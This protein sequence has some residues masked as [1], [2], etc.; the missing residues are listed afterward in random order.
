M[1]KY[2]FCLFII[3]TLVQANS[4]NARVESSIYGIQTGFFGIWVHGEYG[5]TDSMTLRTEIGFDSGLWG[6]SYYEKTGFLL[7]PVITA[8]PRW[9]Y[10]LNKR[11]RKSKRIDGNTGNFIALKSSFHPDWFVI[12]N[13]DNL[14][15]LS[16]ISFVPTWGIRRAIGQHFTFETGI[17]LGYHYVFAKQAGYRDNYGEADLNLHLRIGYRF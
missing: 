4:Q 9:Y 17:G 11:E 3:I 1:K 5:L 15:V 16:D 10:N 6:G 8:E 13:Y 12:S 14:Q 2:F 7:T